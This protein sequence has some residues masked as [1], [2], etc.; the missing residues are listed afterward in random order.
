MLKLIMRQNADHSQNNTVYRWI[1]WNNYR[2]IDGKNLLQKLMKRIKCNKKLF[3]FE[4]SKTTCCDI[5]VRYVSNN[6]V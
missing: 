2:I 4:S 3:K 5:K 1:K 6:G